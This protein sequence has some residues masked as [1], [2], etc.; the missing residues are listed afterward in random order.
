[1]A[2]SYTYQLTMRSGPTPGQV[3]PLEMQEIVIGRDT[4]A[5][6]QINDAEV[7][8]RHARL[9]MQSG[10]YVIE[11]LGSTNGTFVNGQRL[12]GPYM[13]KHGD[14]VMMGEKI[15][16]FFEALQTDLDATIA[17]VPPL[18]QEAPTLPPAPAPSYQAPSPRVTAP[19]ASPPP[20]GP[21][22]TG[23]VTPGPLEEASLAGGEAP[24]APRNKAMPWILAG[25]GCLTILCLGVLAVLWYIDA[26]F[27]WCNVFPFLPGC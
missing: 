7:S 22:Y 9:F 25:C 2:P 18:V 6:L 5:T 4:S 1:M 20:P 17:S 10:G 13:L 14:T 12:S 8:R 3:I 11:D 26:N 23:Q 19:S 21:M 16:L 15:S 24:A 27:L